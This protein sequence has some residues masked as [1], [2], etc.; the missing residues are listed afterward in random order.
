MKGINRGLD[1]FASQFTQYVQAEGSAAAEDETAGFKEFKPT[2]W[3]EAICC[4]NGM[5]CW[6]DAFAKKVFLSNTKK[7]YYA[8]WATL[9][10]ATKL[11]NELNKENVAK[12]EAKSKKD[13][14]DSKAA[15]DKTALALKTLNNQMTTLNKDKVG[16]AAAI[17]AL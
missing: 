3:K 13:F 2:A 7:E 5:D 11:F 14:A 4:M 1:I 8:K 15:A 9:Q 16:N 17:T 12:A 6:T 10:T